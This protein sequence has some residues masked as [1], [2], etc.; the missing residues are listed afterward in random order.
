MIGRILLAACI[1]ASPLAAFADT[2]VLAHEGGVRDGKTWGESYSTYSSNGRIRVDVTGDGET[3]PS[4]S[5]LFL[6]QPDRLYVLQGGSVSLLDRGT[7][8]ALEAKLGAP[9]GGSAPR[10][11]PLETHRTAQGFACSDFDLQR[12]GQPVRHLCLTPA[13]SLKLSPTFVADMR[14][15]QSLLTRFATAVARSQGQP[16]DAFNIYALTE[17][18]PV[19]AWET[20]NGATTWESQLLSVKEG[21]VSPD[22]FKAPEAAK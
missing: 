20:S 4:M 21:P 10:I 22:L 6:R 12:D 14:E 17:G 3:S 1:A 18:Y 16:S 7:L 13:K 9:A 2:T 5:F 8:D 15:M 11:T 19:R